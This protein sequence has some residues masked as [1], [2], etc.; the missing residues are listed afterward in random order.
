MRV[1]FALFAVATLF[2]LGC[3]PDPPPPA[4]TEETIPFRSDG[5]LDI[6]QAG[7]RLLTLDIEIA[8]TDSAMERGMMQRATLPDM[9]GMLFIFPDEQMRSFWMAN[10][11][12]A[13]D[14]LFIDRAGEIVN[15]VKYTKPFSPNNVLSTA[16]AMYVL[17]VEAGFADTHGLAAG[18]QII[19][20]RRVETRSYGE[21]EDA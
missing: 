15:I 16:P 7:E 12:I 21:G 8:D 1:F 17:E 10:T 2:L 18:Q 5:T 3:E 20:S 14:I 6:L 9:S 11:P 13:L 4:E 19:W